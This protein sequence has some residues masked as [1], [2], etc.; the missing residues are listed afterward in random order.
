VDD[1][2]RAT[3]EAEGTLGQ[4][5]DTHKKIKRLAPVLNDVASV[6]CDD[7]VAILQCDIDVAVVGM[8]CG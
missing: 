1:T 8:S 2:T 5:T 7:G 3:A 6:N 4:T